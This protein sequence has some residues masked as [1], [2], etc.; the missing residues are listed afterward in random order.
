VVAAEGN[1]FEH[2][3]LKDYGDCL[4]HYHGKGVITLEDGKKFDCL[5]EAGQLTSGQVLLLCDFLPPLPTYLGISATK[6]EGTTFDGF[7]ILATE[8]FS[9]TSYLPDIP[10]DRSSGVWAAFHIHE[11]IV[12]IAEDRRS[13]SVHF[14]IT[15]FEFLG[16]ERIQQSD[17]YF[18]HFLPLNLQSKGG[19]S[20]LSIKPLDQ[21]DKIM[22]RVR[23]L[24]GIAVSCELLVEI[25]TGCNI[26]EVTEL[27]SDLCYILSVARGTKIQWVYYDSYDGSGKLLS[28]NLCSRITKPYCPLEIIH[29]LAGG[30]KETEAFIEQAYP[31]YVNKRERYKL[32]KG[33][34]DAHLDAKAE[35]DYLEMRGV[36][37]VVA[38]EMLRAVVLEL[39]CAFVK[40]YVI[41]DQKFKELVSTL[42]RAVDDVLKKENIDK[43]SRR[44]IC[45]DKKVL[46]LNRRSFA[47]FLRKLC[48]HVGLEVKENEIRQFVEFRNKLV[49]RGRF[50]CA[51]ATPDEQNQCEPLPSKW[52]EYCFLVNFLDR[53]FLK[54]LGYRGPYIDWKIPGSPTRRE[55]V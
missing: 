24:K 23:T 45:N 48:R 29:P 5:F 41:T 6:F 26:T 10:L 15:N 13:Q 16:T 55:Q 20:K 8:A 39:P 34:I 33:T 27:V 52:H 54:L 42:C 53:V 28:R 30:G 40:E 50:Y 38:M 31:A 46:E 36:K 12:Q 22:Q 19:S 43:D 25:P 9:E 1:S 21:Y 47:H 3:L 44:A 32:D 18:C 14:G 37:L 51:I 2:S 17:N 4:C 49:H 11:I 7:R 35:A